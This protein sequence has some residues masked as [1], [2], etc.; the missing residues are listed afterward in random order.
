MEDNYFASV[1]AIIIKD[2]DVLLVRHTYGDAKMKLLNPSGYLNY[3]ELP[4]EALK[5]EV[6]EETGAVIEPKGLLA[7]RCGAKDWWLTF[8]ADYI[9]G[10]IRTDESENNEVLFMPI[11][12]ALKHP[13]VTDSTKILIKLTKKQKVYTTNDE[14]SLLLSKYGIMFSA[15]D[16]T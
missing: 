6:F 9:S 16:T 13:D 11:D 1:G 3:G 5:R 2:N 10:I 15:D 4:Y 14:Y 7:V 8:L 12:K